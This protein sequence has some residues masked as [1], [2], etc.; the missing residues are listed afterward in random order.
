MTGAFLFYLNNDLFQTFRDFIL[1][2]IAIPAA[3]LTDFFQKRNNF[4]DAL[5]HLWSQISSS[6]NEARQYTYRT[7]ASEDEYRKILIGLSRSIDEVRS[8]Y[9]NLGESKESIGYYP[10]ESLKLMYELFG[11]LGFGQLDPVKAKHAREQ[12]DHYWKNFKESFLWEFDRPEPESFN[13]PNDYGD[14]SK[15]N[16]MKWNENG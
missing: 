4:E 15:N 7:E 5:R 9:K 16:F 8:V 14:R 3:L 13:T 12:L 2:L 6:V 1:L 10:F 11:D